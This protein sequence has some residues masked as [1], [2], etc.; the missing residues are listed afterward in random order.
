MMR[1]GSFRY[2]S[3]ALCCAVLLLAAI[4]P[5]GHSPALAVLPAFFILD[6]PVAQ[7]FSHTRSQ[8]APASTHLARTSTPRAPPLT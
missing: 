7:A 6:A 8:V 2:L 5:L 4:A 1:H 3:V